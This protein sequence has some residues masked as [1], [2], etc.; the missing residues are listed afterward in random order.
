MTQPSTPACVLVLASASPRRRELLALL[1]VPFLVIPADID[2]TPPDGHSPEQV[3]VALAR[4]KA[5][6]VAARLREGIILGADT[7][8]VYEQSVLG[9]PAD[10]G[11]A[12]NMLRRL[13]G[14]EHQVYTGI[15][16]IDVRG[17][18]VVREHSEAVCTRV[19]FRQ[20]S[21]AHLMRY[22]NTGEP[23]DKA[24]AYGAQ[25]YGATLIER[26]EGCFFNVVGLPVSRVCAVLEAWGV[27]PLVEG[28]SPPNASTLRKNLQNPPQNG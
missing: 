15:S 28:T 1:G 16:L 25:G 24:G 6:A 23:M 18:A 27:A 7:I 19:W 10:T 12:L 20:V 4:E 3:T 14:R 5:M 9:K 22:V 11:E 17:G 21:E 13:N 8:V 26:L 2:E